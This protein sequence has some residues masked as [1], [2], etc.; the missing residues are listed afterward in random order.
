MNLSR[1]AAVL[2]RFRRVTAVGVFV[3][4]FLAIFASYRIGSGGLTPRGSETWTAVSSILVTQP[5][6]PEGRVTLPTTQ[7]N[8]AV[9]PA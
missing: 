7:V 1:H 4:I 9:I 5:G 6:F 8:D 3:G 2:W